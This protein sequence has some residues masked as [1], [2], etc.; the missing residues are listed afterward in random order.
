MP[1][2]SV[3]LIYFKA[4][5]VP[6]FCCQRKGP[7]GKLSE[8]SSNKVALTSLDRT[9]LTFSLL[10]KKK[11]LTTDPLR[12]LL[13]L[14]SYESTVCGAVPLHTLDH[15]YTPGC[16]VCT[17]VCLVCLIQSVLTLRL[18]MSGIR[19]STNPTMNHIAVKFILLLLRTM[20]C[21]QMP[22]KKV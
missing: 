13:L 14:V 11:K 5:D 16:L 3:F 7:R 15:A 4:A 22:L 9:Q 20:R 18:Q 2:S 8:S 21:C 12:T 19:P 10:H 17:F 1:A 6:P